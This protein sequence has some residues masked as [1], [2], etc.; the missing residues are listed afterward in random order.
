MCDSTK[1]GRDYLVSFAGADEVD[2][3]VTDE[4]APDRYLEA[5][6]GNAGIAVLSN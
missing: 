4:G 1:F 5:F 2:V 6:N 3:V